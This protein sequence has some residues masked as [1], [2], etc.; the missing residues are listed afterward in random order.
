MTAGGIIVDGCVLALLVFFAVWGGKKGLLGTIFGVLAGLVGLLLTWKLYPLVGDLLT[1]LGLRD[2]IQAGLEAKLG[3]PE[4]A[5]LSQETAAIEALALPQ[6]LKD[7]LIQNNNYEVYETLG[8]SSFGGYIAGYLANLAVNILSVLLTFALSMVLVRLISG[9]LGFL[10]K[11]PLL[12]NVNQLL[13]AAAGLLLG[14]LLVW[15]IFLL[16]TF[17]GVATMFTPVL[18]AVEESKLA[19]F[20]YD[21][22]WLLTLSSRIF[23]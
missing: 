5:G 8:V 22:N 10:N 2:S 18:E 6:M 13:G 9:L 1:S 16:L 17:L 11:I 3:L 23:R 19:S 14:L 4:T 7:W 12:G 21:H 20:L 15:G